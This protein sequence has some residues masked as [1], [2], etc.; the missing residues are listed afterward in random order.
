ML[1]KGHGFVPQDWPDMAMTDEIAQS[2]H[3]T[4]PR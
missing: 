1:G 4:Q 3:D 2:I